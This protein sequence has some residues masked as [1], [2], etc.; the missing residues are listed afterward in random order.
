MIMNIKQT[1]CGDPFTVYTNM[2]LLHYIPV[3]NVICQLYL[4]KK[5]KK[6]IL[7]TLSKMQAFKI[8][9]VE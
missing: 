7:Q 4:R 5:L 2:K 1:Y 3:T 6:Y 9:L 8:N